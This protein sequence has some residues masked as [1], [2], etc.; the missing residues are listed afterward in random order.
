MSVDCTA[1]YGYG[2][3]VSADEISEIPDELIDDFQDS[4][5]HHTIDC[6]TDEAPHFFGLILHSAECGWAVPL[7]VRDNFA[8]HDFL[9]MV[10]EFKKFFPKR[11]ASDIKHYLISSIG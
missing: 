11:K 3:L 8:P 10:Q 5:F 7:P 9:K 1:R 6:Y 2:F 4:E